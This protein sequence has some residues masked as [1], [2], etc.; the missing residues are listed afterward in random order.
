MKI[1]IQI[2]NELNTTKTLRTGR[3]VVPGVT[4]RW[5]LGRFEPKKRKSNHRIARGPPHYN[6]MIMNV[7]LQIIWLSADYGWSA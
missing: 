5:Y 1:I 3:H 4:R 6:M 7:L 2:G